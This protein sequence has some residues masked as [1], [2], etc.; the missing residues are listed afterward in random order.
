MGFVMVYLAIAIVRH[1]CPKSPET[2]NIEN[3]WLYK[4]QQEDRQRESTK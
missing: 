3:M 2:N 1:I 4:Q